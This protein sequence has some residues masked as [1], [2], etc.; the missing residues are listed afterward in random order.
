MLQDVDYIVVAPIVE[1]GWDSALQEAKNAGI[2]VILADRMVD[3]DESLYTLLRGR[4]LCKRRG[5]SRPVGWR[6]I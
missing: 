5:R 3:A 6:T 2:P 4:Q 1:S